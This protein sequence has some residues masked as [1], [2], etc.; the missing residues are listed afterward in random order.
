MDYADIVQLVG[1][2]P[3]EADSVLFLWVTD[4][5][6]ER[7]LDL[8]NDMGFTYKTVAFTWVKKTKHG[9]DHMGTGYYTRA[10]PETAGHPLGTRLKSLEDNKIVNLNGERFDLEEEEDEDLSPETL[11]NSAREIDWEQLMVVGTDKRGQL[12]VIGNIE[13]ASEC[14]LLIDRVKLKLLEIL[15]L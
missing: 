11:F 4:P 5:M 1:S 7:G 10:N 9:K 14:N 3:V 6:L 15:D 13:S 8:I 2:V 12:N